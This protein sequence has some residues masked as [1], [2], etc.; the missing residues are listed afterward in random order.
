VSG[1]RRQGHTEHLKT[2]ENRRD[3]A[4]RAFDQASRELERDKEKRP[5]DFER[6]LTAEIR[7]ERFSRSDGGSC[8]VFDPVDRCDPYVEKIAHHRH[9][10]SN[11]SMP[12]TCPRELGFRG[13]VP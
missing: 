13:N 8:D 1:S 3:E 7:R 4:W 6:R 10:A 11:M 2:L 12:S 5:G 9:I